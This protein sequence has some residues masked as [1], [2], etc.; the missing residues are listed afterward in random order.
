MRV[1]RVGREI[2]PVSG[3]IAL[4]QDKK[5]E[6]EEGEEERGRGEGGDET[7]EAAC[8]GRVM[9][10]GK[11]SEKEDLSGVAG[12]AGSVKQSALCAPN[13]GMAPTRA[14]ARVVPYAY[15]RACNS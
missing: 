5:G 12:G 7:E 3:R 9:E 6:S 2:L 15:A 13:C 1:F 14:H 8:G 4:R 10:A 11:E